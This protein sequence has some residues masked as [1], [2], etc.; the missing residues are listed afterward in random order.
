MCE[1][2]PCDNLGQIMLFVSVFPEGCLTSVLHPA[3]L[4]PAL[5]GWVVGTEVL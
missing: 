5:E 2:S 4:G 3:M 1:M